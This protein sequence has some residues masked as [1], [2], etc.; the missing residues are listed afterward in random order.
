MLQQAWEAWGSL[1]GSWEGMTLALVVSWLLAY[2]GVGV[3]AKVWDWRWRRR[4]RKEG[5]GLF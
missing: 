2:V 4:I 1:V 3:W 5:H